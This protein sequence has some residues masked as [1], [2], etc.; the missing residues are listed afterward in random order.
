MDELPL[1]ANLHTV[2]Q[3]YMIGDS[4]LV[5]PVLEESSDTVDGYFPGGRI[6][7][8]LWNTQDSIDTRV[9]TTSAEKHTIQASLR[10]GISGPIGVHAVG[11]S[12]IPMQQSALTTA[13]VVKS[14]MKLVVALPGVVSNTNSVIQHED[15]SLV[16]N[17]VVYHDDG[18]SL[19]D[20]KPRSC[21][22]INISVVVH[23]QSN[24]TGN[25][26]GSLTISFGALTS[27]GFVP[28]DVNVV[29][30]SSQVVEW[31]MLGSVEVLGWQNTAPVATSN[32]Q[33]KTTAVAKESQLA[34]EVVNMDVDV[35]QDQ[36]VLK[37][38]LGG[39][40][41]QCGKGVSV[42]WSSTVTSQV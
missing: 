12:V 38:E 10:D 37:L 33:I 14:P 15:S 23:V 8:N 26:H 6:W 5:T 41:L 34:E 36:S 2:D 32:V 35:V 31:P 19:D 18:E 21:N 40:A 29:L 25:H 4:I 28:I 24:A 3:Q 39:V 7:Y 9:S 16:A 30:N 27:R 13:D 20:G 11:G 17:G 1:T 22:A 42:T